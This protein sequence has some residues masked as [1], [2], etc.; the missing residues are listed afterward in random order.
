MDNT[1]VFY[2]ALAGVRGSGERW[3]WE[4]AALTSQSAQREYVDNF[5]NRYAFEQTLR[6]GSYNFLNPSSA[7][8]ALDALRLQTKRPGWYSLHSL[9]VKASTTLWELPAGTV[10]FAW[11]AE[12][13]KESLDSRT[14]AQVLSGTELRPAINVVNG[15][16]QVS[17]A[18][19]V[20]ATTTMTS[21]RR[22]RRK[23]RCA[24]SRWTACCCA[25]RSHVVSA[26][27]RCLRARRARPSAT[28]R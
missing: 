22:S 4:A 1:Q 19:L 7:P 25:A 28:A 21:A 26:P 2:R 8:G 15:E 12:F 5:V 11:G 18:W 20:A 23:W 3:E 27:P 13:R 6:D 9:N 24:G 17:A 14:S 16:R 10:G